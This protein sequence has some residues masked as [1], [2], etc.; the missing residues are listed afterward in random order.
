MRKMRRLVIAL[1]LGAGLGVPSSALG[2]VLVP[3]GKS[4]ANQYFEDIPTSMGNA[5]PPGTGPGSGTT[6]SPA[7]INHLGHGR[8]GSASLARL[9]KDGQ[10]AAAL[11]QQTAPTPAGRATGGAT[12]S[13]GSTGS[14]SATSPQVSGG[15]AAGAVADALGG[16][17]SG[18]GLGLMFP[19]LLAAGVA[20]ALG[21]GAWRLRRTAGQSG[22]PG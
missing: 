21:L 7:A 10:A 2:V 8:A 14:P 3:P 5:A 17:S 1:L 9:G 20:A 12:T 19:I 6:S 11:A 15:S 22:L 18:G 16:T 13:G 4:G